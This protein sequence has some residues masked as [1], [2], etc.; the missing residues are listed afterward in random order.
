MR[1]RRSCA[2]AQYLLVKLGDKLSLNAWA[3]ISLM[4]ASPYRIASALHKELD[5]HIETRVLSGV[6][7]G[8]V[9]M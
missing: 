1:S 7:D 5:S 9:T 4:L 6:R 2:E 3:I 8:N